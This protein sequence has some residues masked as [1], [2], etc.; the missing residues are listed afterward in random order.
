MPE[1]GEDLCRAKPSTTRLCAPLSP[2]PLPHPMHPGRGAQL[3]QASVLSRVPLHRSH[4]Y[5]RRSRRRIPAARKGAAMFV[6][7]ESIS[8][9]Q[10]G[11]V[12]LG[13]SWS[14]QRA[15][16]RTPPRSTASVAPPTPSRCALLFAGRP[17][18]GGSCPRKTHTSRKRTPPL[19]RRAP[20]HSLETKKGAGPSHGRHTPPHPRERPP[21]PE[22]SFSALPLIRWRPRKGRV[23]PRKTRPPGRLSFF[24]SS[25]S[26][27]IGWKKGGA[28]SSG[29]RATPLEATSLFPRGVPFHSL[30]TLR[31]VA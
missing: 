26:P 13:S 11:P 23:L 30:E 14:V 2:L 19:L 24:S 18:R 22:S 12:Q 29:E 17:G 25:G 8:P 28:G 1:S 21:P 16:V 9:E 10:R 20:A 7:T 27:L 6:P 15:E 31:G 4:L 5:L 3:T